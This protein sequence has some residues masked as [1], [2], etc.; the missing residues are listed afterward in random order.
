MT[1]Y[2]IEKDIP[3]PEPR[4]SSG[5]TATLRQMAPGDS[6]LVGDSKAVGLVAY[7]RKTMPEGTKFTTRKEGD[8]RRVWRIA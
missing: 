5:L 3:V 7:A 1:K 8:S 4:A 2:Q 6:I